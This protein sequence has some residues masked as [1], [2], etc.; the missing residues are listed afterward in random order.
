MLRRKWL[1][2]AIFALVLFLQVLYVVWTSKVSEPATSPAAA[3]PTATPAPAKLPAAAPPSTPGSVL[4]SLASALPLASL[5]GPTVRHVAALVLREMSPPV[6][7]TVQ[8]FA[9]NLPADWAVQIFCCSEQLR[10]QLADSRLQTLLAVRRV[11]LTP[12]DCSGP[13]TLRASFWQQCLGD[14]VLLFSVGSILC[15]G[16]NFSVAD[17]LGWD[18]VGIAQADTQPFGVLPEKGVGGAFSLRSKSTAL[19]V[20]QSAQPDSTEPE[21][22][23]FVRQLPTVGGKVAPGTVANQFVLSQYPVTGALGV[24]YPWVRSP[25]VIAGADAFIQDIE[26]YCPEYRVVGMYNHTAAEG[27]DG[28]KP[29]SPT[30]PGAQPSPSPKASVAFQPS[31]SLP[32]MPSTP[33][34]K[35]GLVLVTGARNPVAAAIAHTAQQLGYGVIAVDDFPPWARVEYAVPPPASGSPPAAASA[36][37]AAAP[38][39]VLA[40]NITDLQ[41]LAFLFQRFPAFRHVYHVVPDGHDAVHRLSPLFLAS[42][43]NS[44][45]SWLALITDHEPTDVPT[46]PAAGAYPAALFAFRLQLAAAQRR[47]PAVAAL[48]VHVPKGHWQAV[49]GTAIAAAVHGGKQ[50]PGASVKVSDLPRSPLVPNIPAACLMRP[51]TGPPAYPDGRRRVPQAA[52]L[53]ETEFS[54]LFVPL[55]V[56]YLNNLPPTW[57]LQLFLPR[58]TQLLVRTSRL[59]RW[60]DRGRIVLTDLPE[61]VSLSPQAP[62]D[63][64]DPLLTSPAFWEQCIG[65]HLLLLSLDAVLCGN[66]EHSF[67]SF[68]H[69]DMIGPVIPGTTPVQFDGQ[70]SLRSRAWMLQVLQMVPYS[71]GPEHEYFLTALRNAG[72]L[73]PPVEAAHEFA[74]H[75][76]ATR[77]PMAVFRPAAPAPG[78]NLDKFK[79][80]LETWC[81]EY[82]MIRKYEAQPPRKVF[83][84]HQPWQVHLGDWDSDQRDQGTR[85]CSKEAGVCECNGTVRFGVTGRFLAKEV[86]DK[87]PCTVAAFGGDPAFNTFKHCV[88]VP[89]PDPSSRRP[90]TQPAVLVTR[91]Q[92]RLGSLVASALHHLGYFVVAVDSWSSAHPLWLP[93]DLRAKETFIMKNVLL[94]DAAGVAEVLRRFGPFAAIVHLDHPTPDFVALAT[95]LHAAAL[96][97]G[98]ALVA[99]LLEPTQPEFAVAVKSQLAAATALRWALVEVGANASALPGKLRPLARLVVGVLNATVEA[100]PGKPSLLPAHVVVGPEHSFHTPYAAINALPLPVTAEERGLECALHYAATVSKNGVLIESRFPETFVPLVQTYLTLLPDEWTIQL[101]GSPFTLSRTQASRLRFLI[102]QGRLVLTPLPNQDWAKGAHEIT[103]LLLTKESF[104]QSCRGEKLLFFQL[105]SVLCS[106]SQYSVDEFLQFDWIGAAWSHYPP[107][108]GKNFLPPTGGNG[109]L[110]IRSRPKMMEVLRRFPWQGSGLPEDVFFSKHLPQVGGLVAGWGYADKFS[111]E[112]RWSIGSAGVHQPWV[113]G[114]A[115]VHD[116]DGFIRELEDFCPEYKLV[117]RYGQSQVGAGKKPSSGDMGPAPPAQCPLPPQA[118]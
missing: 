26:L 99:V 10:Q 7:P 103:N 83:H 71:G 22:H 13:V 34:H 60:V 94:G 78:P 85:A 100:A 113:K 16:S 88:C 53:V 97:N 44:N 81:P 12:F 95:L 5:T 68:L 66:Y 48:T 8:N 23:F 6:V 3:S 43:L 104:W 63:L 90:H 18:F 92:S 51:A 29:P 11:F 31:C 25:Q 42:A 59:R 46:A 14:K 41:F 77:Q 28:K 58:A 47:A 62:S 37:A 4:A 57:P 2:G 93:A 108:T 52:V 87:V 76:E 84:Y 54:H 107:F 110:S 118:P 20:L 30:S 24:H 32:P 114:P 80:L 82:R 15:S 115:I 21:D 64:W 61:V 96:H 72:A 69:F 33:P 116:P 109:G 70:F 112:G 117:G 75:A 105:D 91:A 27:P 55:V 9:A 98:P 106:N 67:D 40:G 36:A 50:T 1:I 56:N 45:P 111:T 17:F 49:S 38:I 79:A 65:D 19:Q 73:L 39:Q 35:L 86:T 74:L 89:R 101:F 102:K